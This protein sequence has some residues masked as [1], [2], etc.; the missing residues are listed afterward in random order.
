VKLGFFLVLAGLVVAASLGA[1]GDL[2]L[3]TP[4]ADQQK[5][6]ETACL[7][8]AG[9]DVKDDVPSGGGPG[10]IAPEW[11]LEVL[12]K[13]DQEHLAWVF[14]FNDEDSA[15]LDADRQKTF[16]EDDPPPKG[17]TIEQRGPEVLRLY[18]DAEQEAQ[19]RGC[20]DKAIK[21]PPK[22]K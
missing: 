14:L 17:V 22:K 18:A 11:E 20:V 8:A 19:I 2:H 5:A 13:S 9:F 16:A 7:H 21:P 4:D 15:K 1:F 3:D 10:N 6:T 12:A